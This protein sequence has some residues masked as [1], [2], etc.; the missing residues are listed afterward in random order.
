M[1][2]LFD[3]VGNKLKGSPF[4][5]WIC[6]LC[7]AMFIIGGIHF[8]EDTTSS[9]LGI[10][11]LELVFHIKPVNMPIAYWTISLTPQIGQTV[12]S[13]MFFLDRKKN[14][15]ALGLALIFFLI[16]FI[17]DLQ[18]RSANHFLP[19][20]GG[21]NIDS[22]TIMA[23]LFTIVF[24][25]VGSELFLSVSTG[26]FLVLFRDAIKQAAILYAGVRE[27]LAFSSIKMQEVRSRVA[28]AKKRAAGASAPS[29]PGSGG[30]G[31]RSHQ[32][33]RG[34][35]NPRQQPLVPHINNGG[36]RRGRDPRQEWGA[37]L[38]PGMD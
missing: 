8:G 36:D 33:Q 29:Q 1:S 37:E 22:T 35:G 18:D 17:S 3:E 13:Y 25:T 30:G 12:L 32:Q 7:V 34:G 26:L 9:R 28:A 19:P 31:D 23:A 6:L 24:F 5:I 38:P 16:D 2:N 27:E 10:A 20:G 4:V 11:L 15:W 21:I 14:K